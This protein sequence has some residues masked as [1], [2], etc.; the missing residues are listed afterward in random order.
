ME[1]KESTA[2]VRS[3]ENYGRGGGGGINSSRREE[4]RSIRLKI[5]LQ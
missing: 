5:P 2:G 3:R 1:E 4:K